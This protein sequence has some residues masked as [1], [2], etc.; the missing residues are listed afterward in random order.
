MS[1]TLIKKNQDL[2]DREQG[3]CKKV[4]GECLSICLAF[5]HFYQTGMSNLGFQTVYRILNDLPYC[6][7][8]RVFLPTPEDEIL[9]R[10]SGLA[11]FSM[12]SQKPLAEFDFVAFALPFENDYP[13]ILKILE[14]GQIPL[15]S[16][17]R[18]E[19]DPM[20][21][22]GGIAVTLNP[23][24]LVDF[25]DAFL[26]GEGEALIPEFF[27]VMKRTGDVGLD[28]VDRLAAAQQSVEGL[29][30]PRFYQVQYTAAQT[31]HSIEPREN[32]YPARIKR[33]GMADINSF[34]TD[35]VMAT[36]DTE[37][38]DL[39][40]TEISRGCSRGCRFCAAGFVYRPV[41]YRNV[42]TLR[43]SLKTGL[44]QGKKIGLLG[45]A[46]SDHP[47]LASICREVLDGGGRFSLSSLRIDRITPDIATLIRQA[48]I[49]TVALAPEAG[50][51]R[52]RRVIRK[53][54]SER[55]IFQ[56]LECLL[57]EDILNLR[58]YFL[59]GLPTETEADI[60]AM[61]H[62]AKQIRHHALAYTAGK[63]TF[64]RVTLSVNQ[65]IPKPQTPFQWHPLADIQVVNRRIKRISQGLRGEP[66]VRILHDLPKWNYIQALLSLGDRRVG[67]LLSAVHRLAGNWS[68]AFK[69]IPLNGDFFVYRDKP[70]SEF[71]PWDFIDCAT[72]RQHL[73]R[74]YRKAM[75]EKS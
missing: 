24:P 60:D 53:E 58:L 14:L 66:G 18:A 12:E 43:P 31:I 17:Q 56:A 50:S 30:C 1:W 9:F 29:Y 73:E 71:L 39:F 54:I 52:L 3:Y 8:E 74:E 70:C 19:G 45:T 22:A 6:L 13:N 41:R 62:M 27:N 47:G 35:Q 55:Q 48:Q 36:A 34:A 16:D 26:I 5:P 25:I 46:I 72:P 10:K 44:S 23:E 33:R 38:G 49:D 21:L 11:L 75:A 4:W 63:K 32:C 40:V 61:I 28:R 57:D 7:C 37:F 20:C 15:R 59:V 65:F 42:E 68:Q 2:L 69:E 67:Q 51:E 64:R